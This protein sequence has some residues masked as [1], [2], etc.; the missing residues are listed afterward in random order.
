MPNE[1]LEGYVQLLYLLLTEYGIPENIYSD[2]HAILIPIKENG[3]TH[4]GYLLRFLEID[5]NNII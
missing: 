2:R 1:C 3:T 4:F 5:S